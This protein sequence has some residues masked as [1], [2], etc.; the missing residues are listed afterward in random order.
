MTTIHEQEPHHLFQCAKKQ[1]KKN[2]FEALQSSQ[3]SNDNKTFPNHR[4]EVTTKTMR[5]DATKDK[6]DAKTQ[7]K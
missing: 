5:N 6:C 1:C 3:Q 4:K 2:K 7:P